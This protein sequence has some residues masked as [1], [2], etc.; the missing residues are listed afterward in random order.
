MS[1][2]PPGI[3]G[4]SP[5]SLQFLLEDKKR[6]FRDCLRLVLEGLGTEGTLKIE[7]TKTKLHQLYA[8]TNATFVAEFAEIQ[9]NFKDANQLQR[10]CVLKVDPE[11]K[12]GIDSSAVLGTSILALI[13]FGALL[14][15]IDSN[16]G[17]RFC[18]GSY[19]RTT[20][21]T[22]LK[23]LDIEDDPH[24]ISGYGINKHSVEGQKH[25][26]TVPQVELTDLVDRLVNS[27]RIVPAHTTFTHF[28]IY[29]CHYIMHREI[30]F[31]S[32]QYGFLGKQNTRD[33]RRTTFSG[34][35]LRSHE[36]EDSTS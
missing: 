3:F 28:C 11:M 26:S 35:V 34:P 20:L 9:S 14:C 16:D 2:I 8:T 25:A 21:E 31:D 18:K 23:G 22:I 12:L 1:A 15:D 33:G 10:L 27:R 19:E 4:G 36:N 32:I 7:D 29:L 24:N 13:R 17:T 6:A 5:R 30:K